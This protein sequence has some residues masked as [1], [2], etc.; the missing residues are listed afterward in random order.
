[1]LIII[2]YIYLINSG[3]YLSRFVMKW[4]KVCIDVCVVVGVLVLIVGVLFLNDKL[5]NVNGC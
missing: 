3:K 1:M 5:I 4:G 2:F